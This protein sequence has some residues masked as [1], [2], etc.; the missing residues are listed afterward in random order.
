MPSK[1][2]SI[3]APPPYSL[4]LPPPLMKLAISAQI[5]TMQATVLPP[6]VQ[7]PVRCAL[8]DL[9]ADVP[10]SPHRRRTKAVESARTGSKSLVNM[11]VGGE[12]SQHVVGGVLHM[13]I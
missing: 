10:C 12:G 13:G 7:E 6:H 3:P 5:L 11:A 8:Q 2:N 4:G 9:A 1:N